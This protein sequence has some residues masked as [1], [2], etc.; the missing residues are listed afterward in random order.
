MKKPTTA[1]AP[2]NILIVDDDPR[3]LAVL[4]SLLDDPGYR[5]VRAESGR[6]ALLALVAEEFALLILDIRM[7]DMSGF[8]LAQII[9]S[10]TK[11]AC[12]PIIFLTA[13]YNEDQHALDGYDIGAVDYLHKPVNPAILRS[14]VAVF[15][16]LHR[17]DRAHQLANFALHAEVAERRSAE[18]RLRDLND[19]LERR[20]AE[21]TEALREADYRKNEFLAILAHELRNPLAP[22][23]NAV[24]LLRVGGDPTPEQQWA[25]DVI[26]RQIQQLTRLIDDL[27]DVNRISRGKIVLKR[28]L[29]ELGE[30]VARVVDT[31][32]R[33]LDDSGH[34]LTISLPPRP[35]YLTADPTRL[36]QVFLNLLNNAIKYTDRG[37]RI[38]IRAELEG[39]EIV[40]S[41]KD[42]GIGIPKDKLSMIFELFSQV[43]DASSR[44]AGGLGIGLALVHRLV[45]MH[46]GTVVAHSAGLGQGSVF[47]VRLPV[48]VEQPKVLP[49]APVDRAIPASRFRVLVVDDN[50][51]SANGLSTL[52]KLMG[53]DVRIAFDGQ[54]AVRIAMEQE[55]HAVVCDIGL[56][57]LGGYEVARAIR[58]APFGE[59]VMLI[60]VTGWGQQ[61]AKQQS[62]AAG[63]D[64]H[65]V[66]PVD[67]VH[68]MNLV[69]AL[70][71][72]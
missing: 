57:H 25:M 71:N 63:F 21:R 27:M 32:R 17:T 64:H 3:N 49:A 58:R 62:R 2:I 54:E 28:E 38:E 16:A 10:R 4:E 56:P 61:A 5:I 34:E 41:I 30:V 22:V 52:F 37:G 18:Q 51:D 48:L 50:R 1:D 70:A 15:A 55:P 31:S 72:R 44:C 59:H 67:P 24:E 23:R 8:E 60:A 12:I 33:E 29:V 66:K 36:T 35:V 65:L 43:D 68:L 11:T 9:K 13:F 14:K 42:T 20:V 45:E 47:V 46:G 69:A 40:V 6:Q 39:D 19:N 53:N 7:P 26:D